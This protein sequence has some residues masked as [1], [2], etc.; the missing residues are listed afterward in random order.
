MYIVICILNSLIALLL[1][2]VIYTLFRPDTYIYL[3]VHT[4]LP[5]PTFDFPA[6]V[7]VSVLKGYLVDALWAY[8]LT[9]ALCVVIKPI[10]AGV[11]SVAMGVVWEVCQLC[12]IC[13]GTFDCLDILMYLT[14][15][16]IAVL[17]IKSIVKRRKMR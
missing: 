6:T 4:L 12:D 8:A 17:I 3:W 14:A 10:S 16:V 2:G 9:F 11:L 5:L 1:G 15:S 7:F 13:S